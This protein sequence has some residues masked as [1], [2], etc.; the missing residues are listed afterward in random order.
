LILP[1]TRIFCEDAGMAGNET[2]GD[3]LNR[4]WRAEGYES[5]S[6]FAR[7]LGIGTSRY[8]NYEGGLPLRIDVAQ[9]IVQLVPGSSLDWLYN[10]VESGLTLDLRQRLAS[11]T[12]K[13]K[14]RPAASQR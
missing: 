14:R 4:L 3:R 1:G 9:K 6:A 11:V 13:S 12:P 5:A 7:A 10:G 2:V 8:L